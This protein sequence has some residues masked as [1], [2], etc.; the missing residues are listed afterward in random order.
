MTIKIDEKMCIGC[1]L[2][3]EICKDVFKMDDDKGKVKVIARKN[4]PNV[5]EAI[6][7]CPVDAISK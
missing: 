4:I 1:A 5:K 7:N 6:E 3:E 2:C